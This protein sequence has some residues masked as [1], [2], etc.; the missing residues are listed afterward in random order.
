MSTA[1]LEETALEAPTSNLNANQGTTLSAPAAALPSAT[2]A[3]T[4]VTEN[5]ADT[6][7]QS[8]ANALDTVTGDDAADIAVQAVAIPA[9]PSVPRTLT[10]ADAIV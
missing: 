7:E 6:V 4:T 1:P 9:A 2:D 5:L 10:I 8:V 3:T